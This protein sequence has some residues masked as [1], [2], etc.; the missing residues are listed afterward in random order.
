MLQ[1][2]NVFLNLLVTLCEHNAVVRDKE[3]SQGS[4]QAS[5]TGSNAAEGHSTA[6]SVGK[7]AKPAHMSF[8]EGMPP[9]AFAYPAPGMPA[10]KS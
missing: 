3:E 2:P 4:T 5:E 1:H 7:A 10:I 8:P 9:A 6:D